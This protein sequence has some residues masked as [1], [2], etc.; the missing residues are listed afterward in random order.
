MNSTNA[1]KSY[2]HFL[3]ELAQVK[4]FG[5]V[6]SNNNRYMHLQWLWIMTVAACT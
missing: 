3:F 6:L 4:H 1:G 2:P 5:L